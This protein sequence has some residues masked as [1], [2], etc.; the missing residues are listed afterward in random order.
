[1]SSRSN[2]R[3]DKSNTAACFFLIR[4]YPDILGRSRIITT[5]TKKKNKKFLMGVTTLKQ[6]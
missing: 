4:S 6:T 5:S 2:L 3:A 1:M